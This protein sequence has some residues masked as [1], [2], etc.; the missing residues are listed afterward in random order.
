M[1][2]QRPLTH[3]EMLLEVCKRTG[4]D[5]T[6]VRSIMFRFFNGIMKMCKGNKFVIL[7]KGMFQPTTFYKRYAENKAWAKRVR[8][9]YVIRKQQ[10]RIRARSI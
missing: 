3:H 6:T 8:R 1:S 7:G 10:K 5:V 4:Y 9:L 2:K